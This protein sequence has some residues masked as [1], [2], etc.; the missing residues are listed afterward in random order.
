MSAALRQT[1]LKDR[2]AGSMTG[3]HGNAVERRDRLIL[4]AN[5]TTI[6]LRRTGASLMIG[7]TS[8]AIHSHLWRTQH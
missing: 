6:G 3:C 1:D 7:T 2:S 4:M 8:D 5:A